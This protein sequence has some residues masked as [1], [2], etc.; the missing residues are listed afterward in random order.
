MVN[1]KNGKVY[2]GGSVSINGKK[3]IIDGIV[4]DDDFEGV[5]K[6]IIEG[7]VGPIKT[8]CDVEVYGKVDGYV[9]AGGSVTCED[10]EGN[11]NAGG[12]V[13]CNDVGGDVDAGGS[14]DCEDVGG[15]IDAGGSVR[16]K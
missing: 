4:Q 11:V 1:Y 5:V 3:I 16:H 2:K 8:D 15:D 7:T 6:L 10:V 13:R 12:S 9:D 14:V